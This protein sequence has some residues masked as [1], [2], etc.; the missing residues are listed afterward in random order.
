MLIASTLRFLPPICH[1]NAGGSINLDLPQ[2]EGYLSPL[3]HPPGLHPYHLSEGNESIKQ[4][5]V[6]L[7]NKAGDL[8][9][10]ICFPF[11]PVKSTL[12]H[13]IWHVFSLAV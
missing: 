12:A 5:T 1:Y 9:S 6:T 3:P 8:L 4:V 10:Y 13:S 2:H 11:T 7:S